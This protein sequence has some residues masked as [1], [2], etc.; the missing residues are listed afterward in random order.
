MAKTEGGRGRADGQP[1]ENV[2][3]PPRSFGELVLWGIDRFNET[4]GNGRTP[5]G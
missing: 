3:N 4:P 1:G 5:V 2:K